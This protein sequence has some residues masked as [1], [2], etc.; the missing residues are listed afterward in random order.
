MTQI[1]HVQRSPAVVPLLSLR[2]IRQHALLAFYLLAFAISWIGILLLVGGPGIAMDSPEFM[3]AMMAWLAG[4]SIAGIVMT[5]VVDGWTGLRDL[6]ARL[7]RWRVG[8]QWF[9]VA[10][11]TAPLVDLAISLGLSIVSP[12]FLPNIVKASDKVSVIAMAMAYGLIGGGFLEELGWTGFA[13][14][15]FRARYGLLGTG[16]LAGLLWG[17]YHFS[18]IYWTGA[19]VGALGLVVFLVQLFAWLPAYRILMVW[20]YDRTQSLLLAMLMHAS[21]TASM[22]LFQPITISGLPLLTYLL[23]F[24][25]VLWVLAALV[26]VTSGR[27]E[28]QPAPT[29]SAAAPRLRAHA[30]D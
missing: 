1:A 24:A 29:G 8:A 9:V 26:I 6:R 23:L 25:A 10:L 2:F 17:A 16:L 5:A 21:L 12:D 22:I 11:V 28:R 7:G 14:P 13:V 4:P 27:N 15:R 30:F 3:I 20:V 18:I 19:P